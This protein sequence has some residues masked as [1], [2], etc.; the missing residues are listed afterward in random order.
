MASL[1]LPDGY[2]LDPTSR[3]LLIGGEQ[4]KAYCMQCSEWPSA[5]LGHAGIAASRLG[6]YE[7]RVRRKRCPH[8]QGTAQGWVYSGP[9][10]RCFAGLLS[11]CLDRS[12]EVSVA[13]LVPSLAAVIRG[14]RR[15][16]AISGSASRVLRWLKIADVRTATVASL[17]APGR[18]CRRPMPS[19]RRP[20]STSWRSAIVS[21]RGQR[22]PAQGDGLL[23]ANVLPE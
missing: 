22:G 16:L 18:W 23:R 9:A 15:S 7:G 12:G 17:V 20:N 4:R 3:C 1:A 5:R 19:R 11:S 14:W 13:M 21:W 10:K 8:L 6:S 2:I